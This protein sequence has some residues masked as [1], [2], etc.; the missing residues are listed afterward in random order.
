MQGHKETEGK[1]PYELDWRFIEQMAQRMQINKG[2]YPPYNWKNP[3]ELKDL[4][5]A[6]TRH[7]IE[8]LDGNYNDEGELDHL[9]AIAC[10]AMMLWYQ[11]KH[12][13]PSTV[14]N[15]IAVK[16]LEIKTSMGPDYYY[17][18]IKDCPYLAQPHAGDDITGYACCYVDPTTLKTVREYSSENCFKP[19]PASHF[20]SEYVKVD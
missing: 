10:N 16:S 9:P 19:I 6:L 18:W 12:Y 3:I 7:M 8:V 13:V 15:E 11:L 1:L 20:I 4:L 17:Y 14:G 5:D 2:K